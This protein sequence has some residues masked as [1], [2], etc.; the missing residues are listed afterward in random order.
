MEF[1][2]SAGYLQCVRSDFVLFSTA[3][4][5]PTSDLSSFLCCPQVDKL[6]EAESQRKT[7]EEVT[8]PQP[9]VF[10]RFTGSVTPWGD[11]L[12]DSLNWRK[13]PPAVKTA[14][15]ELQ[16]L[17]L[18]LL[19][20]SEKQLV[21]L[22]VSINQTCTYWMT[23]IVTQF[24]KNSSMQPNVSPCGRQTTDIVFSIGKPDTQR[25]VI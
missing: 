22:K 10:G 7:E 23:V 13:L 20:T 11:R 18:C 17:C 6:E 16:Y 12:C 3:C 1:R 8:E 5:W 15:C 19:N 21:V 4:E 24:T 9:M 14:G 25:Y 2:V